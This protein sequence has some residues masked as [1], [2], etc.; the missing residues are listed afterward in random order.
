MPSA[1]YSEKR[2]VLYSLLRWSFYTPIIVVMVQ[3]VKLP[4]SPI[5]S[6]SHPT[7]VCMCGV[8]SQLEFLL[9]KKDKDA[10]FW[11]HLLADA[12]R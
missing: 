3:F 1:K 5:G 2:Q 4:A 9:E 10:E 6:L 8:F 11:G 12:V 7:C